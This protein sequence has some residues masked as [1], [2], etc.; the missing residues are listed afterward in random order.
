M[1]RSVLQVPTLLVDRPGMTSVVLSTAAVGPVVPLMQCLWEVKRSQREADYSRL[2]TAEVKTAWRFT[3]IS[4][5]LF[6][7]R[8]LISLI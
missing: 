2:S 7:A 5:H 3:S 1:A 8:C 6:M 4:A